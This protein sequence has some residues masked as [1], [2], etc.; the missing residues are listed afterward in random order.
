MTKFDHL[1]YLSIEKYFKLKIIS[2][3]IKTYI[4]F[5]YSFQH[6]M[7]INRIIIGYT[8]WT[9]F[10]LDTK[11]LDEEGAEGYVDNEEKNPDYE[12]SGQQNRNVKQNEQINECNVEPFSEEDSNNDRNDVQNIFTSFNNWIGVQLMGT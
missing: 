5:V 8:K 3:N 11:L 2:F 10:I 6:I 7:H 4:I 9:N 1:K 12:F